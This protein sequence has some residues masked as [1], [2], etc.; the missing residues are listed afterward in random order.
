MPRSYN[1]L[2]AAFAL[3]KASLVAML[4]SP[5]SVVFSLLF[6]VIFIVVFGSMVDN[7]IV[8]LKIVL[9][10]G[11][12]TA[13]P[14]YKAISN[15]SNITVDTNLNMKDA[16]RSLQKGR[17]TAILDI[18]KTIP[19]SPVPKYDI[20]ITSSASSAGQK[21]LLQTLLKNAIA[22]IDEKIFPAN[23]SIASIHNKELPGRVYRQID[24]ILPGQ[25]GFSLLMAGVFGSSSFVRSLSDNSPSKSVLSVC[26]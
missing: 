2:H 26:C 7:S 11:C 9:A 4:R 22:S 12:D 13:N 21:T 3:A 20:N 17:L 8:Q 24:F 15:I 5:T 23:P 14:V 19:A 6:P 25:L 16:T 10:P 1:Q 18:R